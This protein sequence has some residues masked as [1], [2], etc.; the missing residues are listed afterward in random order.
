MRKIVITLSILA[1]IA[2]SCGQ[3]TKKQTETTDTEFVIK[4]EENNTIVAEETYPLG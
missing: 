2:S 3:A 4:Q 1:L